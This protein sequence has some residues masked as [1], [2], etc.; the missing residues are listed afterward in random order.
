MHRGLRRLTPP[1][2]ILALA[3]CACDD[4]PV[5]RCFD[6]QGITLADGDAPRLGPEDATVELT[7][8]GDF[9]CPGTADLW[10]GLVP[11]LDRL[12]ADGRGDALDV[13]FHHF[14]LTSIHERA[15]AAALAAAAAHRQGE[16]RFWTLFPMLLKPAVELDDADIS[17]YAAA[18]GLD[19]ERFAA[20][21]G[22][23]EVAAVVDRDASLARSLRFA[24]T[25]SVLLC[26]IQISPDP[27]DVVGNLEHLIY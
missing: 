20:D 13:R 4:F 2:A 22:S 23:A 24:G 12:A 19:M 8:F 6:G 18:A 5:E 7:I 10:F 1:A 27:D 26:G 16:D 3:I 11:F 14:P 17:A 21:R 25:P 15:Y 9:Q